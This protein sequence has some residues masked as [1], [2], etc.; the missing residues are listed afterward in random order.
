MPRQSGFTLVEIM[1]V[2]VIVGLL[3]SMVNLNFSDRAAQQETEQFAQKLDVAF[4]RYRE[5]AVFQNL[6]LGVGW[7]PGE[8]QLIGFYDLRQKSVAEGLTEEELSRLQENPWAP[9]DI[10]LASAI[11]IPETMDVKLFVNDEEL[12]PPEAPDENGALP[13]LIFLSS[14]EYLPFVFELYHQDDESFVI[15][16]IGDGI[17]PVR[18]RLERVDG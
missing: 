8:L 12:D 17:G 18:R 16:L 7:V 9:I 14:D 5:E 6:D 13:T 4:N 2:L 3:L 1:V 11:E 10:A 15:R